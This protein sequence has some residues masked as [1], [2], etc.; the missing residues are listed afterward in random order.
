MIIVLICI[1]T[2]L[3]ITRRILF[4]WGFRY[5]KVLYKICT[6]AKT[7]NINKLHLPIRWQLMF[8]QWSLITKINYNFEYQARLMTIPYYYHIMNFK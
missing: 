7:T 6:E 5:Y 2:Q 4:V 8:D 1:C 3:S